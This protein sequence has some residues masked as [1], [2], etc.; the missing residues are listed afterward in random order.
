LVFD[1]KDERQREKQGALSCVSRDGT[2]LLD[3][4]VAASDLSTDSCP[5]GLI[6]FHFACYSA[7]TPKWDEFSTNGDPKLKAPSPFTARLPQ[8]LLSHHRGGA[9][10]VIGHIERAWTYSFEGALTTQINV[11]EDAVRCILR[12][13]PVGLALELFNFRHSQLSAE[14]FSLQ[15]REKREPMGGNRDWEF[16]DVYCATQDA[17]NYVVL[18][19]PA[20]RLSPVVHRTNLGEKA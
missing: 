17:R 4:S 5:H 10:A 13:E 16:A 2:S 12:G 1:A 15:K 20:V 6:A 18:G 19:D 14:L 3:T 7:G 11:F 8:R 9:L